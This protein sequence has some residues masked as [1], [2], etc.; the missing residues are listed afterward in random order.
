MSNPAL[1][2]MIA[3]RQGRQ[4]EHVRRRA[5]P[6]M[7]DGDSLCREA[8]YELFKACKKTVG[9]ARTFWPVVEPGRRFV[10]GWHLDCVGEHLD[11]VSDPES[12]EMPDLIIN[13]PPRT[14]KSLMTCVFWFCKVWATQPATRWMF[15]SF[16]QDLITRDSQR[17]RDVIKHRLYRRLWD[18][19]ISPQRDTQL[20]FHNTHQGVRQC[21]TTRGSGGM[22]EG[23]DFLIIDDPQN[24]K[25]AASQVERENTIRWYRSTFSRR[26]NDER[27]VRKVVI[28]QRLNDRDLTGYLIA[29]QM[30]WHHLVLPMRYE[31][32]RYFLP[33]AV[34][35]QTVAG[36]AAEAVA[37]LER[38]AR[39]AGLVLPPLPGGEVV[40]VSALAVGD[41]PGEAAPPSRPR[42]AIVPTPLQLRRPDLM[43]GP[44]GSKREHEGD[45]LWPARFPERA[46][47]KAEMELGPEAP[48]QYAQRP[49]GE[50]GDIFTKESF[51]YYDA[52]FDTEEGAEGTFSHTFARVRLRGPEEGQVREFPAGA[53]S[54]LQ[55]IDTAMSENR[56]AAYTA[57]LTFAVTPEH[58]ILL[59]HAFRARVPV[60][61]QF[62]MIAALRD[63]AARW[64]PK[65]KL[66]IPGPRWPFR[67]IAQAVEPK[68]SGIGLISQARAAG[69][70][71]HPLKVDGDKVKRAQPVAVMYKNGQ[72][73][74]PAHRTSW[75]T[76]FEGE[77]L[78]FP[79]GAF[80]DY[81]DCLSYSGQLVINDKII[82]HMITGVTVAEV[83]EPLEETR[84]NVTKVNVG[85]HEV[86]IEW[87][88]DDDG[89]YGA[90][91]GGR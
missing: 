54:F 20:L 12:A 27:T 23:A 91:L 89:L 3:A 30:G 22:G 1:M 51:R 88:D 31:P 35:P 8:A 41:A 47:A 40:T 66:I 75:A 4:S 55:T 29:E 87:P 21:V 58:D 53:L 17:C 15:A 45:L 9:F 28:M 39:E 52:V 16:N 76:D 25:L 19:R 7:P 81:A 74:H 38:A 65:A 62:D 82:R 6:P 26:G 49:T 64:Q 68:A 85:G 80:K 10:P 90:F 61:Y 70:P 73:Y 72:V 77:I 67:V 86:E 18:T 34:K 48:G 79:N 14:S 46:V 13:V 57:C 36:S 33:D 44:T 11:V 43:D 50:S 32:R 42:D 60:Q 78:T 37:A 69:T 71:F 5:A 84:D 2:D 83:G 24:P 63:G 56:R 59:W